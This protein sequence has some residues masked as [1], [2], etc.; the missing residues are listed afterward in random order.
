MS[1][2]FGR[3]GNGPRETSRGSAW[4]GALCRER[5]HIRAWPRDACARP[6]VGK[7]VHTQHSAQNSLLAN[8]L[9]TPQPDSPATCWMQRRPGAGDGRRSHTLCREALRSPCGPVTAADRLT[10][11]C[12][13]TPEEPGTQALFLCKNSSITQMWVG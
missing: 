3:V 6:Q 13:R 7:S 5:R 1:K 9:N 10:L 11:R 12:Y 8:I 4:W 2:R